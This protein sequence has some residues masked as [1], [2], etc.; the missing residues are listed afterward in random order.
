MNKTGMGEGSLFT[1]LVRVF[2][3]NPALS[4]DDLERDFAQS[5]AD[6]WMNRFGDDPVRG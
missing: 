2:L 1:S 6:Y 5:P 3:G 4:L